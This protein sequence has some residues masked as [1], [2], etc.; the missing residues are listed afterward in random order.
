MTQESQDIY[1]TTVKPVNTQL[2]EVNLGELREKL[3]TDRRVFIEFFLQEE[4]THEVPPFHIDIMNRLTDIDMLRVLLAIPRGHAKTTL[5]K[6]TVIWY[7]LF[8]PYEF[9]VYLSNTSPIAKNACRDI[10]EF[11]RTP[12][13]EAVFGKM[14]PSKESE[15]DGL[16]IF[17]I[18][19]G[20]GKKKNCTLRSAGAEQ[21]MRG[22]N[23]N[24]K[25]PQIAVID[26]LEDLANT[27]NENM[28]KNL[29]RWVF[30]TFIKALAPNNK[31]IWLGNM[32]AHTSLLSR[33]SA[34]PKWN[35]VVY[36]CLVKAGDGTL[37]PLWPEIWSLEAIQEDLDEYKD[38]DQVETWYC[39]MMNM[40]GQGTNGF[41]LN[42]INYQPAPNLDD[43]VGAFVTIDPAYGL[44]AILHDQ[45]CV[46]LHGI[47]KDGLT[48]V[49]ETVSGQMTES[50]L[51]D[52]AFDMAQ[53][54]NAWVWGI[55]ATAAQSALLKLFEVYKMMRGDA[56]A[57]LEF[58]PLSPAGRAKS[59]RISA[60]VA[61]M[62]S[63]EGRTPI[64]ALHDQDMEV[65]SQLL[66]YNK[67][68]QNQK[69]D[70]IDACALG[71]DMLEEFMGLILTQ[72][73]IGQ[74]LDVIA[75]KPTYGMEACNV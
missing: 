25:R 45:S 5:A 74:G 40:P 56:A 33:L 2:V 30:S 4:L 12:N 52:A 27:K 53:R 64:Y 20:N 54:W 47:D 48:T 16:W 43:L 22:I 31:I 15:V 28:Q 11:L 73:E 10:M 35:P 63:T 61:S 24:N 7:W 62:D 17:T 70:R 6:I 49:C 59:A 69:D 36:G 37:R 18:L 34:R 3:R 29:D 72:Y 38:M 68:I 39:E 67:T 65:T 41:G 9:C 46:A 32:L 26:D 51:F 50:E 13:F 58:I 55:E 19:D 8:S 60:W 42:Q 71:L 21:Q 14:I 1:G 57:G 23:I 75:P 66:E 44:D